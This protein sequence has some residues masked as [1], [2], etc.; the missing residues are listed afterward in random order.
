MIIK[1]RMGSRHCQFQRKKPSMK[2]C[3]MNLKLTVKAKS[4]LEEIVGF[5]KLMVPDVEMLVHIKARTIGLNTAAS[6]VFRGREVSDQLLHR[7]NC[8]NEH[9]HY[10]KTANH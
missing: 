2:N 6:R 9:S 7:N 5:R 1:K 4:D 10:A 8:T 3:S